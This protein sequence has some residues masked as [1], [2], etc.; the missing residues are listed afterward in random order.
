MKWNTKI[1]FLNKLIRVKFPP[2]GDLFTVEIWRLSTGY[3][4]PKF[5]GL[6]SCQPLLDCLCHGHDSLP[7][8]QCQSLFHNRWSYWRNRSIPQRDGPLTGSGSSTQSSGTLD[9]CFDS[10]FYVTLP[11]SSTDRI[12][13]SEWFLSRF[14]KKVSKRRSRETTAHCVDS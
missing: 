5:N 6:F 4:K 3:W 1:L 10:S 11:W 7:M 14:A 8:T 12:V 13:Y 2:W 9:Q